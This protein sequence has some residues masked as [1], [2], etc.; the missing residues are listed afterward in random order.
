MYLCADGGGSV[1]VTPI[2][3][4]LF[5]LL[6][7]VLQARHA[8]WRAIRSF[9]LQQDGKRLGLFRALTLP[10]ISSPHPLCF[11]FDVQLLH[12]EADRLG[13]SHPW[14]AF[15]HACAM[16]AHTH[17]LLAHVLP[18]MSYYSV[19]AAGGAACALRK[20]ESLQHKSASTLGSLACGFLIPQPQWREG[21]WREEG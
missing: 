7:A 2:R 16:R 13:H 21:W 14:A 15:E 3:P 10:C 20:L 12:V 9:N 4:F 6:W 11:G 5:P 17:A 1:Y 19:N 18:Y 8:P